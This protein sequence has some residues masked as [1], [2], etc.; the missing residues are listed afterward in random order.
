MDSARHFL[1]VPV[2][3]KLLGTMAINKLNVLC[4]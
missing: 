3:N 2:V 4:A 1:P